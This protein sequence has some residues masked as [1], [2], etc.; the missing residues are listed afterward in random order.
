MQKRVKYEQSACRHEH[1]SS[2][3]S[4]TRFRRKRFLKD[5]TLAK[6]QIP[7]KR[8]HLIQVVYD[9]IKEI[10]LHNTVAELSNTGPRQESSVNCHL[11][12]TDTRYADAGTGTPI[13]VRVL[14][15]GDTAI[16]KKQ[17]YADTA[18]IY[19]SKN[20]NYQIILENEID[21]KHYVSKRPT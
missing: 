2:P 18:S 4:W 3:I 20:V 8:S 10:T 9:K 14:R 6:C 7:L 12:I 21:N 16:I 11:S 13:R 15:Y 1:G 17:G 5:S 19:F